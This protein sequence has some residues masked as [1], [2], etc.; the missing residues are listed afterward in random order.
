MKKVVIAAILAASGC[1]SEPMTRF[2]PTPI[3]HQLSEN[4]VSRAIAGALLKHGWAIN[5]HKPGEIIGTLSHDAWSVS[6]RIS[7]DVSSYH[8]QYHD[9]VDFNYDESKQRIDSH[10]RRW[11]TILKRTIDQNLYS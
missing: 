3:V 5:E 1:A 7:Y 4:D 8:L 9:S 11:V 2:E 6:V 10:Y